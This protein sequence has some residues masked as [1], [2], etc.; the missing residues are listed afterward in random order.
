M[1]CYSSSELPVLSNLV[2]EISFNAIL[3][4]LNN[5]KQNKLTNTHNIFTML[6]FIL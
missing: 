5:Y 2:I 6:P 1:D 4:Q 3:L